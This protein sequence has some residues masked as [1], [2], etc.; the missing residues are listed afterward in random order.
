MAAFLQNY[1]DSECF[2]TSTCFAWQAQVVYYY[3]LWSSLL[4]V[5]KQYGSASWHQQCASAVYELCACTENFSFKQQLLH[6]QACGWDWCT[7]LC[8]VLAGVT[9]LPAELSRCFLLIQELD[10]KSKTLQ[11]QVEDRCRKHV[12]DH[13]AEYEVCT[14]VLCFQIPS[15][16]EHL[17]V[18]GLFFWLRGVIMPYE[19]YLEG[20]AFPFLL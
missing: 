7:Q 12:L 11:T 1:V 20:L 4:C 15:S 18:Q 8:G 14:A 2:A 9:D 16:F 3:A 13:T 17:H 5:L 10:Q 19:A 6:S